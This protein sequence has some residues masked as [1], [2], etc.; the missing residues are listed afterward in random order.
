[1]SNSLLRW[2]ATGLGALA[3]VVA[4]P[5][6]HAGAETASVTS[7]AGT[8]GS[9]S[10]DVP[11]TYD[12]VV[13]ARVTAL[14]V[15]AHGA[16]GGNSNGGPPNPPGGLGGRVTATIVVT[17]G[18]T[19]QVRV[20]GR[21]G[22]GSAGSTV[23]GVNGGGAGASSGAIAGGGGGASDVRR[24]GTDLEDRVVVAGGG[25]GAG[26][27]VDGGAGG[28]GGGDTPTAGESGAPMGPRGVGGS[29]GGAAAGGAGGSG[30]PAGGPG[31]AGQGGTGALGGDDGGGGGG[32]WYG[33]GGGGAGF[34]GGGGGGG[35]SG[36]AVDGASGLVFAN[37]VRS[38]D[39]LVELTWVQA[40]PLR[41]PS[42]RYD[43]I[44]TRGSTIIV[45][46]R[47]SDPDGTPVIAVRSYRNGRLYRFERRSTPP[48]FATSF[49]GATGDHKVCVDVLDNPTRQ[50]TAL[51]CKNVRVK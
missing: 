33:G 37:G 44:E 39:G 25:G 19:L 4:A 35:G 48:T 12:F 31:A 3:L 10:Y 36:H 18:E 47:A 24:G 46:G 1:M 45:R 30:Q 49:T 32:G 11:G 38:G 21:G 51:G 50:V 41:L 40:P 2:S 26:A 6:G 15:D 22:D 7:A 8:P 28:A 34:A 42:G 17:P 13:P 27:F 29:A 16:Q 23:G 9:Q 43:T 20:G 5:F 14:T